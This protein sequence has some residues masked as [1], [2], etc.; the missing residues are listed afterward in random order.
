[1]IYPHTSYFESLDCKLTGPAWA[2]RGM[3][4]PAPGRRCGSSRSP[5]SPAAR[6]SGSLDNNIMFNNFDIDDNLFHSSRR[7]LK[8][9]TFTLQLSSYEDTI[10]Y[11]QSVGT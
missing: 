3:R 2:P 11:S 8:A 7:K 10:D 4:P 9:S 6:M 1:M 5:R